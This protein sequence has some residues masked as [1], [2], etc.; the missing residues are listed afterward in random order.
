MPLIV[1]YLAQPLIEPLG[2]GKDDL[3][4]MFC[5]ILS[6]VLSAGFRFVQGTEARNWYSIITGLFVMNEMFEEHTMILPISMAFG[7]Y[8]I[9]FLSQ[10]R[11]SC[12]KYVIAF[13]SIHFSIQS[14]YKIVTGYDRTRDFVIPSMIL[15]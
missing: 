10:E 1:D 4:F 7:A 9:M 6:L 5:L 8:A 14:I 2:M 13:V 15:V 12:N 11:K 3:A